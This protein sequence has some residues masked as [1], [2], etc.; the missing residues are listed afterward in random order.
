MAAGLPVIISDF[1]LWRGLIEK[2][3]C[4]L[5]VDPSSPD[6]IAK[7]ISS[8]ITH[9]ERAEAMGRNGRKAIEMEFNWQTE[10]EKLMALYNRFDETSKSITG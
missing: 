7:A 9:P 10:A 3:D 4:A 1:P 6:E 2:H 5:F 8:N